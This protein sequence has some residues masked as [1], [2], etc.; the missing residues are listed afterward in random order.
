MALEILYGKELSQKDTLLFQKIRTSI[1][2][3]E[4]VLYIVPEQFSFYAEKTL[5]DTLGEAYSH[6][7]ETVNFKRLAMTVNKKYQPNQ[8]DYIDEEIKNLILYRILRS[9]AD[10]LSTVKNRRQSPD[11]VAIFKSILSECKGYLIDHAVFSEMKDKLEEGSF[12][13][14]KISDLDFILTEYQ[15]A[16]TEKFRDFEDSFQSL[17]GYIESEN[18]YKD[19]VIFIDHFN[20]FSP[21]EYLVISALLKQAKT[22]T[23]TLLLEDTLPKSPGELFFPTYKTYNH[24]CNLAKKYNQQIVEVNTNFDSGRFFV[25]LFDGFP[26]EASRVPYS[27]IRAKN[28]KDEVRFVADNILRLAAEGVSFSEIAVL[29][30]DLSLYENEIDEV[31]S[32]AKIP[33]FLDKKT[34]LHE[35]PVSKIFLT[36]FQMVLTDYQKHAV[37]AYLKSLCALFDIH[38]EVCIFEEVMHRFNLQKKELKDSLKWDEKCNF[39]KTQKNFFASKIEIIRKLYDRF[40][41]PVITHFGKKC[42][43]RQA[44]ICYAK[45]TFLESAVK[46]YLEQSEAALRQ[47]TVT[48]YNTILKAI[49]NIDV[50]LAEETIS[51]SDYYMILKQSLELYESGDI[52]DTLDTVTVSDTERGRLLSSAYV[53]ILGMNENVTPKANTNHSYLSDVERE[54]ILDL[55]GIELPTSLFQNCDSN[56][57]LYRSFLIANK[58]LYLSYNVAESEQVK[59]MPCYLWSRLSGFQEVTDF[60]ASYVNISEYSEK[61]LITY[62]NPYKQK[63]NPKMIPE[64]FWEN[65][66]KEKLLYTWQQID[67]MKKTGYY[68]P[69]KKLSKRIMKTRYQKQL[70]T[71]VSQ[72]ETY[73]K[74]KYMYFINYILKVRE[75]ED[76]S[77]D[78]RRTG[79]IVHNLFDIFSKRLKSDGLSWE[80]LTEDYIEKTAQEIVPREIMRMFPELSLYNPRTKYLIQK[81]KRL[82]KRAISYIQEHFLKGDFLPVGYEVPIGDDG[83]PPLSIQLE[84]GSLMQLYGKIDRF[85]AALLDDRLYVRII[86]YKS[87]AKEFKFAL[88]KEGIQLQLLTYLR[89]VVKNGGKYLDF[90]GEIL[91]GAAFYTSFNDELVPFKERP[92]PD[93][94]EKAIRKKFKMRGFVLNDD[95]LIRAIDRHLGEEISYQSTVT[96]IKVTKDGQY[97]L[98]NF[99]FL[100]EFNRLLNDCENTLKSIGATMLSGDIAIKPYRYGPQTACDYCPYGGVCMFDN[101]MNPYRYVEKLSKEDYFLLKSKEKAGAEDVNKIY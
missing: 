41:K 85:D 71:S 25:D 15:K 77:Y 98:G 76:N 100:E 3:Q 79:S 44:F 70:T 50:L 82:L 45:E 40:L 49:K 75:R 57:A 73:Q 68:E 38:E 90:T 34:P 28:I 51:I 23:I 26:K 80:T 89:T 58:H 74:C 39:L 62:Q 96:D 16:I 61:A 69:N 101:K 88:I 32:E 21:A 9:H 35:N 11:S 78:F 48:A 53:F 95:S 84:D 29:T 30:G 97:S 2:N 31:F 27:L 1:D 81:I 22:V 63:L 64:D 46:H 19:Y 13:H 18:L 6:L 4:N 36:L 12:L 94:S 20:Q 59:R 24:L 83:I 47:E 55:T 17:A 8:L 66:N 56:L 72:L 91:P 52:P 37:L 86:D 10:Q 54:M 14:Q 60:S 87:S 99:L 43:Y 5:L 67:A 42:N 65:P 33:C 7:T 92:A 93:E